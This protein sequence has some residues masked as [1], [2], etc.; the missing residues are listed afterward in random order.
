M[1]DRASYLLQQDK[2]RFVLTTAI[3]PDLS[4]TAKAIADHVVRHGD[5]V[6]DLAL[7]VDDARDAFAKAV[8]RGAMPVHEPRCR[9]RRARRGR[10]RRHPHL[11][12]DDPLARRAAELHAGLFLPGFRAVTPHYQPA[13]GRAQVR[14][15]LRR[16][17]R[18]GEDE[19]VGAVLRRRHGLPQ[20]AHLRRQGHQHRVLVADVEGDGE[21]ERPHQVPD[22]RAGRA[23]RRSRRSRSTS[24]STAARACSTWR[25]P[26]TTSWRR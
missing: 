25:S 11:R 26:P 12:R 8:E 15:P 9:A 4:D 19:R 7:W 3:R 20:P 23:A 2:I 22:Q 1:R 13:V 16:Q 14:R 21:R 24:T 18:A 17:R 5:G 10:D 6:R